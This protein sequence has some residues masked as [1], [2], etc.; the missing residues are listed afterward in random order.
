LVC[1][2]PKNG[3]IDS[4]AIYR[5]QCLTHSTLYNIRWQMAEEF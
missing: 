5:Q 4:A 2:V 1:V 3:G